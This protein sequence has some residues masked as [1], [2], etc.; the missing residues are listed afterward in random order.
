LY[1]ERRRI[2]LQQGRR[3]RQSGRARREEGEAVREYSKGG[4]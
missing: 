1:S 3:V 4:V 2:S